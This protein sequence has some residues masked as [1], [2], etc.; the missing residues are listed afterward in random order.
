MDATDIYYENQSHIKLI[1]NLMFHDK[2]K[3]IEIK[4]QYIWDM[5]KRGVMKLQYVPTEEQVDDA[6]TK[7][8]SCVNF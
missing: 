6:V 4:F 3:N 1:E 7:P 5:V 8:L 2:S